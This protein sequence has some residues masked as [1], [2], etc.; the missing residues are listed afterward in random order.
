MRAASPPLLS[1]TETTPPRSGVTPPGAHGTSTPA[2]AAS[3]CATPASGS[4]RRGSDA[5]APSTLA[6]TAVVPIAGGRLTNKSEL[7]RRR[8]LTRRSVSFK[9]EHVDTPDEDGCTP[10]MSAVVC[11]PLPVVMKLLEAGARPNMQ[12]QDQTNALMQA[13]AH[14]ASA[15]CAGGVIRALLEYRADPFQ[16]VESEERRRW[17]TAM[18]A[19]ASNERVEAINALVEHVAARE[20]ARIAEARHS[21]SIGGGGG[22]GGASGGGSGLGPVH[23]SPLGSPVARGS[24]GRCSPPVFQLSGAVPAVAREP[25]ERG[26]MSRSEA[27]RDAKV[28]TLTIAPPPLA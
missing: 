11:A 14:T 17:R 2:A 16:T 15:A 3:A 7:G 19:A 27:R 28:G 24:S 18:G 4:G 22:G 23:E 1:A 20:K 26:M 13:C 21:G 8:L 12:R 10:L 5:A 9:F 6:A 25:S